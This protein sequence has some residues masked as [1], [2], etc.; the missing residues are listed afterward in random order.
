MVKNKIVMNI[1]INIVLGKM[2]ILLKELITI[3]SKKVNNISLMGIG[4]NG[5]GRNENNR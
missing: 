2:A 5:G 4:V 1:V 3:Q